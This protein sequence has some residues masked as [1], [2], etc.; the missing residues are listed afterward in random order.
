MELPSGATVTKHRIDQFTAQI[1]TTLAEN[2]DLSFFNDLLAEFSHKNDVSPEEI[3][4]AL[5]FLLQKERPLQVKFTDVKP[6]RSTRD[7]RSG[8]DERSA[9]APRENSSFE[10]GRSE[11]PREDRPRR[12]HNDENMVRY[13]I[14]VG[15]NHEARPGDIV[16]AIANEAGISSANI[17][18]IKLHDEFSTVDLPKGLSGDV[19]S[20]LKKVRVR[21]RPL[22][23]SVDNSGASG[24]ER[25][26]RDR[27]PRSAA[28]KRESS[29]KPRS[30]TD[31]PREGAP[32]G[33]LSL[34][35]KPKESKSKSFRPKKF[36]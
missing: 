5:A 35:D 12:E 20:H 24:G 16:G 7:E 29:D 25:G 26:L 31:R 17:G 2:P 36:D 11:R 22:D 32:R 13:R 18:H 3:A 10:G 6:E 23:I 1:S 28:E 30:F 27:A 21:N 8:R 15:R 9:R 33:K 19:L 14:E 34:S 4:S